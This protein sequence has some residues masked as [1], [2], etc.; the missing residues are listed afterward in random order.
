MGTKGTRKR[1][2]KQSKS[3]VE[4]EKAKKN[5]KTIGI[6]SIIALLLITIIA[7]LFMEKVL[8][9]HYYNHFQILS[10]VELVQVQVPLVKIIVHLLLVKCY[11][12]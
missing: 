2:I 5:V 3:D 11:V 10:Q 12:K 8:M 6:V 9:Q 1:V 4:F 7:L